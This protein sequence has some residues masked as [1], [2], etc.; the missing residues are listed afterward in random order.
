MDESSTPQPSMQSN[1]QSAS[2]I[3]PSAITPEKLKSKRKAIIAG[4]IIL[5]LLIAVGSAFAAYRYMNKPSKQET[6]KITKVPTITPRTIDSIAGWKTYTNTQYG[7]EMKHPNLNINKCS[8]G[9]EEGFTIIAV[10][11]KGSG[12]ADSEYC[13]K[14]VISVSRGSYYKNFDPLIEDITLSLKYVGIKQDAQIITQESLGQLK[15]TKLQYKDSPY[16]YYLFNNLGNTSTYIIDVLGNS[17]DTN[18]IDQILSTFKFITPTPI[19]S[20]T[21]PQKISCNTNVDCPSGDTCTV[22]GPVRID[23]PQNKYCTAPG[24]PVPL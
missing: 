21:L 18:E 16:T 10:F 4:V 8:V 11:T 22:W 19:P 9:V 2:P 14:Y 15:V 5:V 17:S 20:P 23:E 13:G 6:N 3:P 24:Q 1:T 12:R 7:F